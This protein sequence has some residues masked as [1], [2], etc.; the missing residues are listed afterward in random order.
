MCEQYSLLAVVATN[1]TALINSSACTVANG[2]TIKVLG[3]PDGSLLALGQLGKYMLII[4]SERLVVTFMGSTVAHLLC[5]ERSESTWSN[6]EG[7]V[8]S[9]LWSILR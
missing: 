6:E 7:V 4:P 2:G 8:L 5:E 3:L 1:N 9:R